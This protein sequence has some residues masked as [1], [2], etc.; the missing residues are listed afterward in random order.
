MNDHT[1]GVVTQRPNRV[2]AAI[3][4]SPDFQIRVANW[5]M[6][7]SKKKK[8]R[9]LFCHNLAFAGTLVPNTMT[10]K[11]VAY[12]VY[13]QSSIYVHLY[14]RTFDL[15][16]IVI[17]PITLYTYSNLIYVLHLTYSNSIYVLSKVS[18]SNN[19]V[20]ILKYKGPIE[21]H[22]DFGESVQQA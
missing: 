3:Y 6:L 5:K 18:I 17:E 10:N 14:L 20:C 22:G 2:G 19:R 21:L 16:T 12:E 7:V 1:V 4:V 15:R 9:S 8:N 11:Q 13:S